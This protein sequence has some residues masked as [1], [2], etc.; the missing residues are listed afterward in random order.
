[1]DKYIHTFVSTKNSWDSTVVFFGVL[2]VLSFVILITYL[3]K[4]ENNFTTKIKSPFNVLLLT[5]AIVSTSIMLYAWQ[6]TSDLDKVVLTEEGIIT[7]FGSC[8]FS[9]IK[10]ASF[11]SILP[12]GESDSTKF[13]LIE[14]YTGKAHPINGDNYDVNAILK[15]LQKYLAERMQ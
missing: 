15:E 12:N 11:V 7:P 2:A 13:L 14:E 9:N 1:M 10:D 5:T 8:K 3:F 4:S 6:S